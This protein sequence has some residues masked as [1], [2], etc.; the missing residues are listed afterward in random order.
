MSETVPLAPPN[1]RLQVAI[2]ALLVAAALATTF[3][4]RI[5]VSAFVAVVVLASYLDLRR[6]LAPWGHLVTALL[7]G[8]GVA[9]F[10]WSGYS[11]RLDLLA[12]TAAALT[13]A[14]LASRVLLNEITS[15]AS[16]TTQDV[17]ATLGAAGTAGV[18]G[19]HLLLIR[20]VPLFGFR[21]LLAFG[22]M[23]VGADIAAFVVGRLRARHEL[24][25]RTSR[26]RTTEG[27][28]A[29]FVVSVL[30]GLVS[31]LVWNPP[32]DV[33]SG[34][35]LG[36]AMGILAPV[37]DLVFSALKRSAGV[38]ASGSYLGPMGGA[39]DAIDSV[40]F[41]APAFYWALRTLAL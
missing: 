16:G 20:S 40:L 11:G 27:A 33:R 3:T 2:G 34:L 32:F 39:L 17:A 38:R 18:L 30:I 7:G 12:S 13:L 26:T 24:T 21:G 5:A 19:A 31:G 10:L 9:G 23:V 1:V 22:L 8:A 4:G 35:L 29:G 28:A 25:L 15:K 6:L 37:G 36:A 41:A 14:L